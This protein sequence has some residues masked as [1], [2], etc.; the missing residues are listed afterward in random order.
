MKNKNNSV[1]VCLLLVATQAMAQGRGP[2]EPLVRVAQARIETMATTTVV[3][4]TVISRN[5]ARVAA[6]VEGRLIMVADIGTPLLFGDPVAIIED[7]MLKLRRQEAAAEVVAEEA[8]LE[9]LSSEEKRLTQL[10]TQN[11][12]ARNA[13]EET[14]SNR[15][16]AQ[17]NLTIASIRLAQLDDQLER[18]RVAAPFNGVIVE[19]LRQAG[20]RV[21]LGDAVIRMVNPGSLELIARAPLDYLPFVR[22]HD[23][24]SF[25]VAGQLSQGVVRT[26]VAVGD[27]N[28]HLFE[29]RVDIPG[30]SYPVGQTV[31]LT[32]PA[33]AS[34]QVLAVPRDALV[35]RPEGLAVFVIGPESK[36]E[37]VEVTTG[38]AFGALIEVHGDV[39]AGDTVVVRGNERLRTGQQVQVQQ[40]PGK[41]KSAA[42]AL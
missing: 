28:T 19:R 38:L 23:T 3:P 20:E 35:L 32:L 17:S 15:K 41:T 39:Q 34:R 5:D 6:E 40:S 9:F 37:R 14:R 2:Q 33:S 12:A 42:A 4:G 25:S 1:M 27:E 10:E 11:N 13:L 36:A 16:V 24:V 22:Q 21:K 30:D 29:V 26:L 18:T 31:R 7:T 8:R